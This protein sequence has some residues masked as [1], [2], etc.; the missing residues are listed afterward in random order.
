MIKMPQVKYDLID[1]KGGWDQ[2]TPTQ[3]LPAGYVRDALNFECNVNGGYTR[4]AGY[5]RFD[6]R[7]SPSDALY[8]LVFVAAYV[9]VTPVAG[10]T[11]NDATTGA[12]AIVLA[13]DNVV[14]GQ[15]IAISKRV[16]SFV[17]G[18]NLR[19]GV[20]VVGAMITPTQAISNAA[21]ANY[22]SLA[23][24]LYRTDIQPVPG[25]GRVLG[26]IFY[27]DILYAFRNNAGG[28]AVD[29][30]KSSAA[31]WVSVPFFYEVRFSASWGSYDCK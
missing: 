19:V 16:G 8:S 30:Y 31:G 4:I 24:N 13:T 17:I 5:E 22:L 29:L 18:N 15:V 23:A 20:T 6:G 27:K 28:T 2:N 21:N 10:D 1:M 7:T 25:S 14:N 9:G 11:V 26:T 12:T 3:S